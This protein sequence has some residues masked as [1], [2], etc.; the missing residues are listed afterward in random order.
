MLKKMDERK[1]EFSFRQ[2]IAEALFR[3]VLFEIGNESLN[4]FYLWCKET[5]Y[6]VRDQI[7]IVVSYLIVS[8]QETGELEKFWIRRS[9]GFRFKQS[10]CKSEEC[11]GLVINH[12]YILI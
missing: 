9:G 12:Y 2:I 8:S 10:C 5:A 11:P 7:T 4:K 6:L 3:S 1:R